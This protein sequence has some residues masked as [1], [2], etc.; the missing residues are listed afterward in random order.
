MVRPLR[1]SEPIRSFSPGGGKPLK[2]GFL[3]GDWNK[4]KV[5]AGDVSEGT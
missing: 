4:Q 5:G 1:E 3:G 2:R